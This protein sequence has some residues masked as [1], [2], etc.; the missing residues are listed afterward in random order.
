MPVKASVPVQHFFTC[1]CAHFQI[2]HKKTLK[3]CKKLYCK[4]PQMNCKNSKMALSNS[5]IFWA[6][7][8]FL[9]L[10]GL[11][12]LKQLVCSVCGCLVNSF[13]D[14]SFIRDDAFGAQ[15]NCLITSDGSLHCPALVIVS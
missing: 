9:Q 1:L 15:K 13:T 10:Y 7:R 2:M 11:H 3:Y 14:I 4:Y 5:V 8:N 6:L 12:G